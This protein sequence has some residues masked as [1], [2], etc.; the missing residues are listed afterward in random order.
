M[1]NHIPKVLREVIYYNEEADRY[2]REPCKDMVTTNKSKREEFFYILKCF[3]HEKFDPNNYEVVLEDYEC[4]DNDDDCICSEDTLRHTYTIRDIKTGF[5]F[6]VGSVCVLRLLDKE[7][8]ES[9]NRLRSQFLEARNMKIR[10]VCKEC[11]KRA[12]ERLTT[13]VGKAGYCSEE[14]MYA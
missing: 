8:K 2:E 1:S 9:A 4:V 11:N 12:V 13:K 3:T 5:R 14:C 10:G 6:K 7:D